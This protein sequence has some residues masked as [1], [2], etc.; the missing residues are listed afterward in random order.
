MVAGHVIGGLAAS[1]YVEKGGL[2]QRF[3]DWTYAFHMPAF[4]VLSGLFL[5]GSLRRGTGPFVLER[6]KSLYYPGVLWSFAYWLPGYL[7]QQFNVSLVNTKSSEVFPHWYFYHPREGLWFLMTLFMLSVAYALVR[8][9]R[10]PALVFLMVA[11][12]GVV[13]CWPMP[14]PKVDEFRAVMLHL[15]WFGTWLAFGA[16]CARTIRESAE[17]T[18]TAVLVLLAIVSCVALTATLAPTDPRQPP[19]LLGAPLGIIMLFAIAAIIGRFQ[20]PALGWMTRGLAFLGERSLEIY[21]VSGF[22]MVAAR[23]LLARFLHITEPGTLLSAGIL[24][25][26]AGPLVLWWLT[27]RLR[28]P[29]LF[30]FGRKA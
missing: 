29:W 28:F 23:I 3:Y 22:G 17:R 25:G 11:V 2:P 7:A 16:A 21:L 30:R 18:P 26:M 20:G 4:L 12:A 10:V 6:L 24:A 13:L 9:V 27:D 15:A 8:R 1:G 19:R 5:E 14:Q